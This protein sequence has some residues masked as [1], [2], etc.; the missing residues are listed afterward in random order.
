VGCSQVGRVA[1]ASEG[2]P[3]LHFWKG[4]V[5]VSTVSPTGRGFQL[6]V[7]IVIVVIAVMVIMMIVVIAIPVAVPVPVP[8]PMVI[9]L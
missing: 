4:G 7:A 2:Y 3:V 8:I 6:S 1:Q 9:V 5:F